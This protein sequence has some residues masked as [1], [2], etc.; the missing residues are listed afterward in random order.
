MNAPDDLLKPLRGL[1]LA[2]LKERATTVESFL[3]HC[4]DGSVPADERDVMMKLAH[5]LA[6]SGTTYGFPL[7]T[8]SARALETALADGVTSPEALAPLA[9]SL[10]HS[11]AQALF[12]IERDSHDASVR[13][14]LPPAVDKPLLLA[15]DDD[16]VIRET[17]VSLFGRDFEVMT[18]ADGSEGLAAVAR[19]MPRLVLVDQTMPRMNGIEFVEALRRTGEEGRDLP[20]IMI[21]AKGRSQD[22][23]AALAAGVSDYIVKPFAPEELAAKARDLLHRSGKTVLIADDDPAIR[24]L[25]AYKFRLAG[26]RVL[27][28]PDGEEAWRLCAEYR[29]HLAVLDRMMPGL[30]GVAVLRKMR[31]LPATREI[32]VMFLTAL[33]QEKDILEGFRTGVSDYVVKPFLP[34]EVL[35]RGMRLLGLD[36]L[37]AEGTGGER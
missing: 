19:R 4:R 13:E 35:V 8:Q 9:E 21:T 2:Q 18:A 23:V 37:D 12:A 3:G 26:V 28:A 5:K 24:D 30:D 7:I 15:V 1:Y 27:T 20:V 34:E 14:T 29:P 32:P 10:A 17:L 11:C 36:S 22:V 6:G 25:L 31:E 33:R 16:P